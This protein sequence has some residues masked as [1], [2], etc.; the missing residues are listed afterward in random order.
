MTV[1]KFIHVLIVVL[2][3]FSQEEDDETDGDVDEVNRVS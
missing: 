2:T 3:V 1:C